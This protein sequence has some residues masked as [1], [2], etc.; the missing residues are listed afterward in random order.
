MLLSL[1]DLDFVTNVFMEIEFEILKEVYF[2]VPIQQYIHKG[3][4]SLL[5]EKQQGSKKK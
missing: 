5:E 1:T 3:H 4:I 2:I